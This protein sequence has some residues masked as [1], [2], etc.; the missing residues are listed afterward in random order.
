[1]GLLQWPIYLL[2]VMAWLTVVQRM[3]FVHSANCGELRRDL[4][5]PR[6]RPAREGVV[7]RTVE[8]HNPGGIRPY[9]PR[10]ESWAMG[11]GS[12]PPLR[13]IVSAVATR[14]PSSCRP[15]LSRPS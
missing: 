8:E 2:A 14:Q 12:D 6:P 4:L 15:L 1:M 3:L 10:E 7:I 11:A 5:S 9:H 13:R